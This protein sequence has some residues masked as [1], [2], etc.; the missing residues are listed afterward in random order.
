MSI[1][2]EATFVNGQLRPKSP[3]PLAE[4]TAVRVTI[5]PLPD[6][7]P[8]AGVIGIGDSGREDGAEHHDQYLYGSKRP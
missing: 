6:E 2:I 1:T 3:I 8:L 4:G 5:T 7:D